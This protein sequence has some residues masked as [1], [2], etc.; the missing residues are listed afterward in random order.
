MRLH[1]TK[2]F[3]LVQKHIQEIHLLVVVLLLLPIF[4]I[5]TH[6]VEMLSASQEKIKEQ[7]KTDQFVFV[8]RATEGMELWAVQGENAHLFGTINALTTE[9][10]MTQHALILVVQH[11]VVAPLAAAPPQDVGVSNTKQS[12]PAL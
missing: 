10:A 8:K 3:V 4:V 9:P 1:V 5:Q 2:L 6:V 12:A 11:F 7:E